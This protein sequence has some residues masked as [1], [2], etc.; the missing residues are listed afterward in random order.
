MECQLIALYVLDDCDAWASH[1]SVCITR[2]TVPQCRDIMISYV[3]E[4]VLYSPT[5]HYL[6]EVS[7]QSYYHYIISD[8]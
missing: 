6:C 4:Q 2:V 5:L 7:K 3:S 1:S 8:Q